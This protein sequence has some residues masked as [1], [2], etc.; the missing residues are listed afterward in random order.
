[1]NEIVTAGSSRNST[2]SVTKLNGGAKRR[3]VGDRAQGPRVPDGV[4]QVS[5]TADTT[6]NNSPPPSI[7]Q[8]LSTSASVAPTRFLIDTLPTALARGAQTHARAPATA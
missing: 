4:D 5:D 3:Q 7:A 1:M 6:S 2:V 8:P